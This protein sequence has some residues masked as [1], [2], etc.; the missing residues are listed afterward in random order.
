[1]RWIAFDLTRPWRYKEGKRLVAVYKKFELDTQYAKPQRLGPT[2]QING[3]F[4]SI[5]SIL[6]QK[7][8]CLRPCLCRVYILLYTFSATNLSTKNIKQNIDRAKFLRVFE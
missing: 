4:F 8:V 7:R 3:V 5:D 6:T 1:M 2:G